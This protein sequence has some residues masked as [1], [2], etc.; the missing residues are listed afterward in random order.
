[1]VPTSLPRGAFELIAEGADQPA[2]IGVF[3]SPKNQHPG[4]SAVLPD[5]IDEVFQAHE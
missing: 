1:M 5:E 4:G 3:R 2:L